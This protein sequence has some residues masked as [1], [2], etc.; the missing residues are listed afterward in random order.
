MML[1]LPSPFPP[2]PAPVPCPELRP[3]LCN[4]AV[5]GEEASAHRCKAGVGWFPLLGTTP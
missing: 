5:L 1:P 2:A 3:E 4:Y